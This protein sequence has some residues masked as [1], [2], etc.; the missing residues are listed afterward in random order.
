[1]TFG[2]TFAVNCKVAKVDSRIRCVMRDLVV[3]FQTY[4]REVLSGLAIYMVY[5]PF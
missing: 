4:T 2:D 5:V 1:M 3:T